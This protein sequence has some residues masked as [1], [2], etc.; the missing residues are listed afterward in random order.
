MCP[1]RLRQNKYKLNRLINIKYHKLN[2]SCFLLL[3]FVGVLEMVFEW[4]R[5]SDEGSNPAADGRSLPPSLPPCRAHCNPSARFVSLSDFLSRKHFGASRLQ[6]PTVHPC[7][8]A[9]SSA[10]LYCLCIGA[11]LYLLTLQRRE[12]PKKRE[13]FLRS[14]NRH[15]SFLLSGA[16]LDNN[17]F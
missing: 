17:P 8:L 1:K 10:Q 2:T 7:S 13:K 5:T 16:C 6:L 11:R 12:K 14:S 4:R 9:Q 15:R 3:Y